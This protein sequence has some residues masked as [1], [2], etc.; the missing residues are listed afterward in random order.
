MLPRHPLVLTLFA[1]FHF[2]LQFVSVVVGIAD[3]PSSMTL[4]HFSRLL[5][6]SPL[7]WVPARI[8][9]LLPSIPSQ[10]SFD[11]GLYTLLAVL[12][13]NSLIWTTVL[14]FGLRAAKAP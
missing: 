3:P 6:L 11:P 1:I 14:S 4:L 10:D 7:Y 12:L 5:L 9:A 8:M 13:V 2:V